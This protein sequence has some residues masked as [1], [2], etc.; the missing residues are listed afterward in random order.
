MLQNAPATVL[1]KARSIKLLI[2][3]ID[4]VM[5]DGRLFFLGDGTE[6]KSFHARDG[7]GLKLLQRSGVETAVISGRNS[8][9]VSLRMESLGIHH[10][11]QGF[12]N[13]REPFE[14]LLQQLALTPEQVAFIGD[15]ILDLPIL[16]RVGLPIAVADAHL[17][18]HAFVD[19]ITPHRGGDGAVRDVCDLIMFAQGTY[20]QAVK[21]HL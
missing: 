21:S 14:A 6:F 4:G 19:W 1:Q 10:V 8:T 20:D 7:Y 13:K 3:D 16:S 17:A 18:I 11:Y 5:T 15:D 2:S 12:E 9:A